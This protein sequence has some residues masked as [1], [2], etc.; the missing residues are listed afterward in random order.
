MPARTKARAPSLED[1]D[2]ED[3]APT[4]AQ[5]L[6]EDGEPMEEDEDNELGEEEDAEEPQRVRIVSF[7]FQIFHHQ[8]NCTNVNLF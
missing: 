7:L 6:T 4:S 3:V 5:Q 8:I 1:A 2:M